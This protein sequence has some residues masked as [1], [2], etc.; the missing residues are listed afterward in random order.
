VNDAF[1]TDDSI[2]NADFDTSAIGDEIRV[3]DHVR[4]MRYCVKISDV[5]LL[6]DLNC[7]I[8]LDAEIANFAVNL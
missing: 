2:Q 8:D 7:V 6:S 4:L 1:F 5:D 3:A